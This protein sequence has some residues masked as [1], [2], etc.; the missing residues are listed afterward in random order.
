MNE[1][2]NR[3]YQYIGRPLLTLRHSYPL[4]SP[5]KF[6]NFSSDEISN[7]PEYRLTADSIGYAH[8]HR[9]ATTIPGIY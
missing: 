9:P 2:V 3:N 8:E 6:Q 5:M 1:P 4:E 7:V